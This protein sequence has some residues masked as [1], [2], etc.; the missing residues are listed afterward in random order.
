MIHRN[1]RNTIIRSDKDTVVVI[2]VL[3]EYPFYM[4]EVDEPFVD[5]AVYKVTFDTFYVLIK[6]GKLKVFRNVVFG[7]KIFV[8]PFIVIFKY[9]SEVGYMLVI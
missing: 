6:L 5:T 8:C 9:V 4:T 7:R 1:P 3:I 2:L